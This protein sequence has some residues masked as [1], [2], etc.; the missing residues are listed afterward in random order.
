MLPQRAYQQRATGM[1]RID[2]ILGLY[3]Q[4]LARISQAE[5]ALGRHEQ[6]LARTLM[7]QAQLAVSGLVCGLEGHADEQSLNFL[8]LY[9]F[10]AHHLSQAS[11]ASAQ[12][13]RQVLQT[14]REAFEAIRPE[15]VRLE[16]EGTIPSLD[17]SHSVQVTA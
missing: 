14:L 15:A 10:V 11:P 13:A 2:T 3:D 4:A 8:R 16:R 17:R 7:N 1:T 9:E 5:N 6:V 12:A